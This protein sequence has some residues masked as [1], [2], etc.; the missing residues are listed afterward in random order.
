MFSS[1]VVATSAVRACTIHEI[2]NIRSRMRT[3][4]RYT[5]GSGSRATTASGTCTASMR[6]KANRKLTTCSTISGANV[7]NICTERMSELAR[8]MSCPDCTRS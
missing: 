8:E 6:P 7:R 4:T 1:T 5:N 2:G 3:P